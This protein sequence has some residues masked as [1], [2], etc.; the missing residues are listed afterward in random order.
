MK[1][2]NKNIEKSEFPK[3]V[4]SSIWL[5]ISPCFAVKKDINVSLQTAGM[6]PNGRNPVY[7]F[8]KKERQ[9]KL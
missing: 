3:I 7:N 8:A 1:E 9:E 4:L 2:Y 6:D 5:W